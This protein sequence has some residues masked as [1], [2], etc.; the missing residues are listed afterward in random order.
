MS[1]TTVLAAVAALCV[2]VL[3]SAEEAPE[4]VR[5]AHG[6]ALPASFA[7]VLPCADCPGIRHQLDLWPAG[8][9][10]LRR[11][12]IDRDEVFDSL[13]RW[14]VD[15]ERRALVLSGP[16]APE[17]QI[18]GNGHLR[19]LDPEG[20]PIDSD[21]PYGLEPAP[22]APFDIAGPLTGEFIYFADAAIFT[23]CMTGQMLP[24]RM[25]AD[26]LALEQAYLEAR[27]APMA[28]VIARID[29]RIAM[30]EPMEGPLRRM[31]T[32]ERLHHVV[33][34]GACAQ[35]RARGALVNTYWRILELDDTDL[36]PEG[37]FPEPYLLLHDAD[38]PRFAAT[39]GCNTLIGG[40]ERDGTTLGFG[41]AAS[42]LM[43]CPPEL[44]GFEATLAQV[45]ATVASYDSDGYRLR[46]RDAEGRVRA[47][48]RSV[49]T[50]PM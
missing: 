6:L 39:V 20:R 36:P 40:F 49:H 15:P 35:G 5:G 33:P 34:G 7:G 29:G 28:P 2:P 46:L 41:A 4:P 21:L 19:L 50:P 22:L 30:G 23:E 8:G 27:V 37:Q 31:V 48:L 13:G 10:A 26:Y 45:L 9:Y 3:A 42:T 32:V 43:A 16:D 17:W 24:V 25:E 47:R 18:L 11:E 14:H 44:A 12:Y 38:G 1:R